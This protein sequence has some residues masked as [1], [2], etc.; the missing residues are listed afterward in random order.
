MSWV[1]QMMKVAK[2]VGDSD[3]SGIAKWTDEQIIAYFNGK[4]GE[5]R[6]AFVWADVCREAK[7]RKLD[8]VP[9]DSKFDFY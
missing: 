1:E 3:I 8:V 6:D 9:D 2:E 7:R 4:E 5:E